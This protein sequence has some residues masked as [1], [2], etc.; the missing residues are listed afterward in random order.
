MAR[1]GEKGTSGVSDEEP[2]PADT[3]KLRLNRVTDE[4]RKLGRRIP[5]HDIATLKL[6]VASAWLH[7]SISGGR[8]R[9]LANA[10]GCKPGEIEALRDAEEQETRQ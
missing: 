1:G 4:E 10:L 9:E 6:C 5:V 8:A 2:S 7:G 3:A